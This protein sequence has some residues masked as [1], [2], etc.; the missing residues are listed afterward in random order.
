MTRRPL[1]LC[2]T[3]AFALAVAP[4]ARAERP[5]PRQS[6]G[7]SSPDVR[8]DGTPLVDAIEFLR[9]ATGLNVHVNWRAL[10]AA[11]VSRVEP[12]TLQLAGVPVGKVLETVLEDAAPGLLSYYVDGR[13]VRVTTRAIADEEL[14]TRI[15]R[16]DD[17]TVDVPDFKGPNLNLTGGAGVGGNGASGG[18]GGGSGGGLFDDAGDED[19]D[20]ATLTKSERGQ[21]LVDLITSTVRPDI[22]QDNGGPAS[23]RYFNGALIVTAP[24]SVQAAIGL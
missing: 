10:E 18:G 24:R 17:L 19:E 21:R 7:R 3:V 4:P 2:L 1:V 22:W 14:V 6:V 23:V 15:Y 5:D 16:V 11:G 8:F 12:V 20:D 13:V 9:D